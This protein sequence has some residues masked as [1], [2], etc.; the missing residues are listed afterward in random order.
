M[1]LFLL[2]TTIC[3]IILWKMGVD[4]FFVLFKCILRCICKF[5]FFYTISNC[6]GQLCCPLEILMLLSTSC[7]WEQKHQMH[8]QQ[9]KNSQI[10]LP[11]PNLYIS[12]ALVKFKYENLIRYTIY[13]FYRMTKM[14]LEYYYQYKM[15]Y[16]YPT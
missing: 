13:V 16:L 3:F 14:S 12:K 11:Y 4:L 9:I 15:Y 5:V 2:K 6:Y 1:F 10:N 7:F 8:L